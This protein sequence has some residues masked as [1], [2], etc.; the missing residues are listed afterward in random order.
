MDCLATDVLKQVKKDELRNRILIIL[1]CGALLFVTNMIWF[2]KWNAPPKQEEEITFELEEEEDNDPLQSIDKK[3]KQKWYF[4]N[5]K[6]F[7]VPELNYFREN[8]NF[9]GL[10]KEVFELRSQGIPL[11]QIADMIDGVTI[12]GVKKISVRINRKIIRVL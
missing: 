11:E 7:T 2:I 8:C 12:D 6:D 1:I 10:E 5:I 3:S 4:M 9:V